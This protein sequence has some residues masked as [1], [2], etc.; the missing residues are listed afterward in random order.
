MSDQCSRQM[1]GR[2]NDK[3]LSQRRNH[4]LS[5]LTLFQ[6]S[7][8]V[9]FDAANTM[10]ELCKLPLGLK[11]FTHMPQRF[12]LEEVEAR[13]YHYT[14]V[15]SNT[16]IPVSLKICQSNSRFWFRFVVQDF[17]ETQSGN[18]RM[19][20]CSDRVYSIWGQNC[21]DIHPC[22]TTRSYTRGQS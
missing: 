1:R 13:L 20:C 9:D 18:L 19:E 11:V 12:I 14:E 17:R 8:T 4:G 21:P 6:C 10:Q 5:V 15:L 7:H 3:H 22:R 2:R 16:Y